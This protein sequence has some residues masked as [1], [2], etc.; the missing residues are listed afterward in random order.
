MPRLD[1]TRWQILSLHLDDALDLS[2]AERAPWLEALR[3]RD[4]ALADDLQ[5]LLE[6]FDA[7][8]REGFLAISPPRPL[9]PASGRTS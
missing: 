3:A 7:L 9:P 2:C 5:A 4:P 6:D 1:P 8:E